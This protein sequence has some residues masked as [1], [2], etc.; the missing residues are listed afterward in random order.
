MLMMTDVEDVDTGKSSTLGV[1]DATQERWAADNAASAVGDTGASWNVPGADP[2]RPEHDQD[3]TGITALHE[4]ASGFS[5]N[6]PTNSNQSSTFGPEHSVGADPTSAAYDEKQQ[7]AE[8][9]SEAPKGDEVQAVKDSK[10]DAEVAQNT[11]INASGTGE[12]LVKTS[13]TKAEG[14]N[15]DAAQPGAGK[16][17]DRE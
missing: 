14:G 2:I 3:K 17:A 5:V 7:G 16:E 8:R 12:N 6:R 10:A 13:G 11:G 4:P 15:F 9:P 1:T